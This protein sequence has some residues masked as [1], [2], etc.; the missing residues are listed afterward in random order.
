MTSV[1]KII[2]QNYFHRKVS[3]IGPVKYRGNLKLKLGKVFKAIT[4]FNRRIIVNMIQI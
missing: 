3:Q 2:D 4:F 1:Y